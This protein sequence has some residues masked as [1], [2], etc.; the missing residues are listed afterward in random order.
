LFCSEEL[1]SVFSA[2]VESEAADLGGVV[3]A[4]TPPMVIGVYATTKKGPHE[5][6][7]GINLYLL[8]RVPGDFEYGGLNHHGHMSHLER[9]PGFGW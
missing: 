4:R 1:R 3:V 2:F 8:A 7:N 6:I 9:Y 5:V